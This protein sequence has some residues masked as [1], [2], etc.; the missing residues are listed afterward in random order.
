MDQFIEDSQAWKDIT[1]ADGKE[2]TDEFFKW[3]LGE[4][5]PGYDIRDL[6]LRSL[7]VEY[8]CEKRT[9]AKLCKYGLDELIN[10]E[11]YIQQA[12]SYVYFYL[13][14]LQNRNPWPSQGPYG[15]EH[16][17]RVAPKHFDGDYTVVP[18]TL[19]TAFHSHYGAKNDL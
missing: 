16:I 2:T 13:Y 12:N 6:A 8:D 17:W 11:E 7:M 15:V 10:I 14:M 3:L 4:E 18:D 5:L 19:Y 9:V 1:L